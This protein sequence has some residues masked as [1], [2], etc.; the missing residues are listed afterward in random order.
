MISGET[1]ARRRYKLHAAVFPMPLA[2]I[3]PK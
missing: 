1:K 3:G 2:V